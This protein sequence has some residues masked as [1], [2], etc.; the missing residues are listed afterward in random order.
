LWDPVIGIAKRAP[1]PDGAETSKVIPSGP[2][3]ISLPRISAAPVPYSVTR[4]RERHAIRTTR[5]S[6]P[7]AIRWPS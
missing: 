4:A 6:S 3:E 2:D 1:L 7:Q 5:G